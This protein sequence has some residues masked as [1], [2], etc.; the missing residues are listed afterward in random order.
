MCLLV[1]LPNLLCACVKPA[2]RA[3]H[4]LIFSEGVNVPC[5][6]DERGTIVVHNT[7]CRFSIEVTLHPERP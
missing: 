1:F 7:T 5:F 2:G 3:H 6:E 4:F